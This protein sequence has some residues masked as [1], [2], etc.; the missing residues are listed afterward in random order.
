ME[1]E[2]QGRLNIR[3]TSRNRNSPTDMSEGSLQMLIKL[4]HV[5]HQLGTSSKLP[6]PV[7]CGLSLDSGQRYERHWRH[8][9]VLQVVNA[10]LASLVVVDYD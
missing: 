5:N 6:Q 10:L 3:G 4:Q 7:I 9:L 8:A 1:L 2:S